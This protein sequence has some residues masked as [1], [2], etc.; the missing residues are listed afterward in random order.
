MRRRVLAGLA[1]GAL[2]AVAFVS[3]IPTLHDR[4]SASRPLLEAAPR[5]VESLQ[6]SCGELRE[7][8]PSPIR[9][10]PYLQQVTP[11]SARILWTSD[12]AGRERV[13]VYA[14]D[15]LGAPRDV[16]LDV[17][18]TSGGAPRTHRAVVEDLEPRGV[19]CYELRDAS[20][21]L[22]YGPVAFRTA[23]RRSGG[24][25]D[26]LVLGD[27]GGGGADQRAVR[28]QM[29]LVPADLILHTGDLAYFVATTDKLEERVFAMYEPLLRT[30]PLYP[31]LGDHDVKADG[32]QPFLDAFDL[33]G[34]ERVY[35]FDYGPVHVAAMDT[36]AEVPERAAWLDE[37]LAESEAPWT[38]VIAHHP[39]FSSGWHGGRANVQEHIVP[40]LVRHD[41][42][43]F[44]AGH[45][46]DYE[47]THPIDGVTYLV[48]GGGGHSVRPVG[49]RPWTAVS[50]A[51]LHFVHLRVTPERM[52]IRAIDATGRVFDRHELT[53][54]RDP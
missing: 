14:V 1:G 20:D 6:A 35:A 34:D 9:R 27:S 8:D 19:Y 3:C 41:V 43:V 54:P 44:I 53:R 42:D 31:V 24:P 17:L 21:R 49:A 13:V 45:D 22:L 18:P 30:I 33:P 23:P 28:D 16:D 32:G 52:V 7:A 10:A 39:P 51:V 48:T 4:R 40:V 38:I 29:L 46:H 5:R 25:V 12:G 36:T 26:V 11:G 50:E 47:R 2:L 37:H 15:G